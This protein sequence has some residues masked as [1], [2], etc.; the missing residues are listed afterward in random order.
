MPRGIN[1]P[2]L[3]SLDG[4]R[5]E[6]RRMERFAEE[7]AWEAR[8]KREASYRKALREGG[9]FDCSD[10]HRALGVEEVSFDATTGKLFHFDS[11]TGQRHEELYA[12]EYDEFE[13]D[14]A[15]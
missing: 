12:H 11:K 15:D 5:A 13:D 1:Q 3:N 10:C 14:L 6:Q 4:R 8:R 7:D 9:R 2:N